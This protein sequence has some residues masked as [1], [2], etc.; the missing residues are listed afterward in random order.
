MAQVKPNVRP[1]G[2]YSKNPETGE[3]TLIQE[4]KRNKGKPAVEAEQTKV[5]AKK[6]VKKT[7]AEK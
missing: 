5:N 3:M 1:G 7:Q 2:S 4:T 6:S